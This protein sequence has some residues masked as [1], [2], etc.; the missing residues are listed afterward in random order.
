MNPRIEQLQANEKFR[1][2][3]VPLD[4]REDFRD[5]TYFLRDDGTFIFS[6]GYYH[7]IEKDRAERKIVSHI[8]FAPGNAARPAP[9]YARKILFDQE[10]E[11]ITKEIMSTQPLDRFY[12]M[13]LKRY[14]DFDPA[15][16]SYPRPV[17][18]RYKSL[19]PLPSLV[20]CFP[21]RH[22]LRAIIAQAS[23]EPSARSVKIVT[24]HTADLLQI[25]VDRIGISGSL[26]LGTYQNPHDLDYVIYGSAAEVKQMVNF[27]YSLTD[28][29]EKRR[30]REFGKYWPIRFWDWAGEEKF[31]VCPFFS[32]RDPEEAP[33]RNFDC[34]NLGEATVEARI[35]DHTHNAFNPS[36]LVLEGAKLDGRDYPPIS[37]FILYHG[38]ERGDWREGYRVRVKGFHVRIATF[39]IQE[40]KR[41]KRE[42]FEAVL[43][44]NLDQAKRLT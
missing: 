5:A 9:D 31:M 4:E 2:F 43:V 33:L 12:P 27:M 10:Y 19:V 35:V 41:E 13:Q 21:H 3:L 37:R 26:S 39:R 36:V 17:Y 25:P 42:E 20:G 11:N 8:V 1:R 40:G 44:N 23:E 28:R 30:V 7:G 32:Y 34:E 29:D 16:A 14:I 18:A 15:Q 6:E 38:G 24:E 22:S